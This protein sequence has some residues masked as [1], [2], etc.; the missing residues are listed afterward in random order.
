[1]YENIKIDVYGKFD[2][3]KIIW[4]L[5]GGGGGEILA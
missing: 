4:P 2:P 1:M 5:M 3:F